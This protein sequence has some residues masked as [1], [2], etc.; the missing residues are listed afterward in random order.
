M[1][2]QGQILCMT[3]KVWSHEC[4]CEHTYMRKY[5]SGFLKEK[6]K[7]RK[8]FVSLNTDLGPAL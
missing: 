4:T 5:L 2:T 1:Y 6:Q 8:A 7:E 3:L